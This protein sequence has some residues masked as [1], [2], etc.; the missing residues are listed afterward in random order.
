M[1]STWWT[2]ALQA[3]TTRDA[4]GNYAYG[5]QTFQ[6]AASIIR[7]DVGGDYANYDAPGLSQL[8]SIARGIGNSQAALAAAAPDTPLADIPI[9]EAP[10]SRPASEQAAL[11]SWQARTE[12]SYVDE[13]GVQQTGVFTVTIPQ[14]LPSTVGSL[15]AQMALRISDMLATPPGTGTPRSGTLASIGPIT[16]LQV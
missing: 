7:S 2:F 5:V 12:V 11:P 10:W 4:E 15:Q 16:V 14:V 3:A 13:A 1:Y 6:A 9:A 8:F